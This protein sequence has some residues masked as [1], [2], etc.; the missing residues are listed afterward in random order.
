[1]QL[2][3]SS[4]R[5]VLEFWRAVEAM[6]PDEINKVAMEHDALGALDLVNEA[7]RR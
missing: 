5:R 6:D 1:M 7:L 2:T 3:G 4:F